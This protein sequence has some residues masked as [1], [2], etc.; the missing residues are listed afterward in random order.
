MGCKG[1]ATSQNCPIVKWN[2]G[3]NWP[4]GCGHPC[5]GCAEPNFWDTM[6]PF[7]EHLPNA[8]GFNAGRWVDTVGLT[9]T[10]LAAAGAVA[11][12]IVQVARRREPK[13]SAEEQEKVK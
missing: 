7:Y 9:L 5:I 11:H 2:E 1:P 13:F 4:V 12:G 8:V 10:G 3:T 6:T